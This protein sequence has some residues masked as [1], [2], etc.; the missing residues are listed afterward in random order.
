[1]MDAYFALKAIDSAQ[2]VSSQPWQT[3]SDKSPAEISVG[4]FFYKDWTCLPYWTLSNTLPLA[5]I[6]SIL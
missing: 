6:S 3:H 1:V 2:G 4:L 5:K